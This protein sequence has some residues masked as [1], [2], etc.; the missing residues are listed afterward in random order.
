MMV[1]DRSREF[2]NADAVTLLFLDRIAGPI[3]DLNVQSRKRL[4]TQ[5]LN[6]PTS[7]HPRDLINHEH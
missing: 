1:G 2:A 4:T 3:E 5:H 6:N 7:H